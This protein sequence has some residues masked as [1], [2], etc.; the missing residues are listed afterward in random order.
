M[1]P[2]IGGPATGSELNHFTNLIRINLDKE[3]EEVPVETLKGLLLR[4]PELI[5]EPLRLNR[6]I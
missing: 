2:G 4:M 6:H 5:W 3:Y 1:S